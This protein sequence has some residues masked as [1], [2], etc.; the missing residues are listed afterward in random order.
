MKRTSSLFLRTTTAIF[1]AGMVACKP[2]PQK[3]LGYA[4]VY[5][6]AE[7]LDN[8]EFLSPQPIVN[9]GKIYQYQQITFQ[10]ETG[11]GIHIINSSNPSSPQ[12][13]GFIKIGGASEISVKN[14][15]L[16]TDNYRDLVGISIANLAS[17]NVISRIEDVFP[18]TE[19]SYP[20][21][22]GVYFE[23]ADPEKGIVVDWTEKQLEN[24]KCKR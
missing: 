23:C 14:N 13:I 5:A 4:P 24:P 12:K 10:M 7:T 2:T 9:G 22:E 19:Q 20:P 6:S 17:P 16:Y 11:K 8:I 1:L 3:V 18:A 15:I 21:H